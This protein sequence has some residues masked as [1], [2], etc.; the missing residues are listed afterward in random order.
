[1]TV[2]SGAAFQGLQSKHLILV[3]RRL[4]V[5]L[6]VEVACNKVHQQLRLLG[7][8][9]ELPPGTLVEIP[10]HPA[11]EIFLLQLV[12]LAEL[13]LLQAFHHGDGFSLAN[14]ANA[15][16]AEPDAVGCFY[17]QNTVAAHGNGRFS[18]KIPGCEIRDLV[19]QCPQQIAQASVQLEANA[20]LAFHHDFLEQGILME[21]GRNAT[22]HIHILVGNTAAMGQM[23]LPQKLRIRHN[24][25]GEFQ[26][27][28][29]K[30]SL[31]VHWLTSSRISITVS[32]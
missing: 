17:L 24:C 19:A 25:L 18:A 20:A 22:D 21:R 16:I 8:G 31:Y 32:S 5:L 12:N 28:T 1:M 13:V 6:A 30:V 15:H 3:K 29:V 7:E 27:Q 11:K 4:R 23:Y 10:Q 26:T 2:Q 9:I 14:F